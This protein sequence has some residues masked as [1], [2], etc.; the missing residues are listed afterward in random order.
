MRL[1]V[2]VEIP[3]STLSFRK[4]LDGIFEVCGV[5]EDMFRYLLV[6]KSFPVSVLI[7]L[8]RSICSAVD[9]LDKAPWEEVRNKEICNRK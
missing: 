7:F 6:K 4:I 1:N 9:K 8:F 2:F 3:I 5:A